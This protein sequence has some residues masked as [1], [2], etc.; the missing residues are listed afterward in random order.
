MN[1][2]FLDF[3]KMASENEE[4]AKEFIELARKYGIEFSGE[5]SEEELDDVSGGVDLASYLLTPT[6]IMGSLFNTFSSAVDAM[7]SDKE[8]ALSS[9][10]DQNEAAEAYGDYL[11]NL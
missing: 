8:S 7:N 3:L 11:K 2:T 1:G 6:G 10:A 4:L 9:L 5:L